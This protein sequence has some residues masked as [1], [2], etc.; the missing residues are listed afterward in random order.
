MM[1]NAMS[2]N[3]QSAVEQLWPLFGRPEMSSASGV[4]PGA[5]VEMPAANGLQSRATAAKHATATIVLHWSTVM[6]IVMAVAAIYLRD[7]TEDKVIRQVLLEA[8][9][10]LGMLVLICVPLRIAV[11][12]WLGFSDQSGGT[13]ALL[14]W[15]AAMTHLALYASL[16]ALPLVGWAATSAK[17]ITLRLFGLVRLPG[18]VAADPDVADALVDYHTWGAWALL[19]LVAAHAVA[20]LWHHFVRRDGVLKAMLPNS[21][22]QG[23]ERNRLLV[24]E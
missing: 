12:Y 2:Q 1:E 17:G 13:A 10:Q 24:A 7:A 3:Q 19:A 5:T 9:R 6:A 11:R 14:R 20:A 8:H 15:A 21:V 18:L 16:I 23:A 4:V 22:P